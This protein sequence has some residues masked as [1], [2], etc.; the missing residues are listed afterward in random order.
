MYE[1]YSCSIFARPPTL[2]RGQVELTDSQPVTKAPG[3]HVIITLKTSGSLAT[4]DRLFLIN[5]C[6]LRAQM[7]TG[8]MAGTI[9]EGPRIQNSWKPHR[10]RSRPHSPTGTS[11]TRA[12][13]L[14]R[15]RFRAIT[16][17]EAA[18]TDTRA[19]LQKGR[20]FVPGSSCSR[21]NEKPRNEACAVKTHPRP[22]DLSIHQTQVTSIQQGAEVVRICVICSST[23][24]PLTSNCNR[25]G[26]PPAR[27][28]RLQHTRRYC[29]QSTIHR[30]PYAQMVCGT[31]GSWMYEY[32]TTAV[33]YCCACTLLLIVGW[34]GNCTCPRFRKNG[35]TT[36]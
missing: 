33:T 8:G 27:I 18:A 30:L 23:T 21:A 24:D 2:K 11:W 34:R 16:H 3:Q 6:V 22:P 12:T 26:Q 35:H 1:Y 17:P 32:T 28:Y 36:S 25:L 10:N 31:W 5:A 19:L 20:G 7:R 14:K 4:T 9:P 15:R 29:L 13:L